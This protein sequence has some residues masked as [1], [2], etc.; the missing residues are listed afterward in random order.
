MG[1]NPLWLWSALF[2]PFDMEGLRVSALKLKF[3]P[4]AVSIIRDE[5]LKPLNL[6]RWFFKFRTHSQSY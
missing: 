1:L 2:Q 3:H 4:A 6:Y 5:I